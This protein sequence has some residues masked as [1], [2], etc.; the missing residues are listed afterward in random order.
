MIA[1]IPVNSSAILAVG[2]DGYTLTVAFHNGRTYDHPG[3]PYS[4]F[5]GLRAASS[6]GAYY[7][8]FIRGRY[9]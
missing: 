4:V 1:L 2:F 6:K 8:A 5:L 9:R 3:V 7:N